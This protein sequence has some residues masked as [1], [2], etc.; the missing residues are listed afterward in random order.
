MAG[1]LGFRVVVVADATA[2]H[3]TT[4]YDGQ[5]HSAQTVHEL[6]LANLNGE[7]ATIRTTEQLLVD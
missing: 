3:E 6:A 5:H 7:F 4:S 2:A 1:D